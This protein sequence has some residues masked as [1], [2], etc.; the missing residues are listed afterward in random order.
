MARGEEEPSKIR[1]DKIMTINDIYTVWDAIHEIAI[2]LEEDGYTS[3]EVRAAADMLRRIKTELWE[4]ERFTVNDSTKLLG[5]NIWVLDHAADEM[6]RIF[7]TI[8]MSDETEDDLTS[9]IELVIEEM[10]MNIPSIAEKHEC[11]DSDDYYENTEHDEDRDPLTDS[12]TETDDIIWDEIDE[13]TMWTPITENVEHIMDWYN[14]RADIEICDVD[15]EMVLDAL[16]ETD[17]DGHLVWKPMTCEQVESVIYD[18]AL[19]TSDN[20]GTRLAEDICDERLDEMWEVIAWA[21]AT[22]LDL[23]DDEELGLGRIWYALTEH[24][25]VWDTP[26]WKHLTREQTYDAIMDIVG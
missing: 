15:D 2:M 3:T 8:I 11:F 19:L 22:T 21:G 24:H 26:D 16:T 23:G 1:K 7:G 10:W 9:D 20:M 13:A 4:A 12:S 25:G 14:A 5:T 6:D 17:E 18:L